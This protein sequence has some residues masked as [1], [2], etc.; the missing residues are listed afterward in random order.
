MYH[1]LKCAKQSAERLIRWGIELRDYNYIIHHIPG[2]ENHWADLLSR[3]GAGISDKEPIVHV[4]ALRESDDSSTSDPIEFIN[5]AIRVQPCKNLVWPDPSEILEEQRLHL[6]NSKLARNSDGL[7][8]E[9]HNRIVIPVQSNDLKRRLC[10]IAHAGCHCSHLSLK[11]TLAM[12]ESW[13]F[14]VGMKQDIKDVCS[15]C[16][17]CLPTRRG[18]RIP[19]PLGAACHGT[20]PNEVLHFDYLYIASKLKSS[21]HYQWIFVIR[22]DF[23]GVVLLTPII[24]PNTAHTVDALLQWRALFGKSNIYVSDQASYFV[25]ETLKQFCKKIGTQQHFVTAYAHYSNGTIEIVNRSIINLLRCMISE[26][27]SDKA[28]WPWFVKLVEHAINHRPQRRLAGRAPITVMTG[29]PADNPLDTIF[30][31]PKM[32]AISSVDIQTDQIIKSIEHLQ[33]SLQHMHKEILSATETERQSHRDC[34]SKHRTLPNFDIGD[35]VLVAIPENKT[36]SKLDFFWHGP[37]R[38]VEVHASYVFTV[39]N[40]LTGEQQKIHG[41][42]VQFYCD[43][44]L[45]ITDDIIQQLQYDMSNRQ[46]EKICDVR[47]D[48][49]STDVEYLVKWRGFSEL[50]NSWCPGKNIRKNFP[51]AIHNFVVHFPNHPFLPIINASLPK[52]RAPV[53]K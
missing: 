27:R 31:N 33:N 15:S 21:L 4:R 23:S 14:W 11:N 26:A 13:V 6:P 1:P 2:E 36:G 28:D 38:V 9:T 49:S 52:V 37:Y 5:S 34:K 17:H 7:L 10:I 30:Y 35:Y 19:R 42:R 39:E 41:D 20:R 45:N 53:S 24:V 3:W 40:L 44:K 46:V 43:K 29:L 8:V 16:L 48:T 47:L 22:D 25:S 50:E 32:L 12:L 51:G 18:F